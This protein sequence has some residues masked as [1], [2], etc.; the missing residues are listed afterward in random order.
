M[1]R[2]TVLAQE[3]ASPS[4]RDNH[5]I[6]RLGDAAA[7]VFRTCHRIDH[8]VTVDA[9]RILKSGHHCLKRLGR[10][11]LLPIR[12]RAHLLLLG[13]LSRSLAATSGGRASNNWGRTSSRPTRRPSR[14]QLRLIHYSPSTRQLTDFYLEQLS[15]EAVH[16]GFL[17]RCSWQISPLCPTVRPRSRTSGSHKQSRWERPSICG[18][19]FWISSAIRRSFRK[20]YKRWRPNAVPRTTR[21]PTL[22][23]VPTRSKR[24][25]IV[26]KY[27]SEFYSCCP[28]VLGLYRKRTGA[29]LPQERV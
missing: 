25:G 11:L 16:P 6:I 13:L 12:E 18:P 23:R 10:S 3:F 19:I 14:Y 26:Q 8:T 27:S 2:K 1:G 9:T 28:E 22:H 5:C 4:A 20:R 17:C 7:S 24:T 29:R 15:M 21:N